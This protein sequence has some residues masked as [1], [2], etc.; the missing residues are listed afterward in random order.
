[1]VVAIPLT[2]NVKADSATY[3][4]LIQPTRK[5]GLSVP[6]VAKIGAIMTLD[7]PKFDYQ[8]GTLDQPD[9]VDIDQQ[10]KLMM[11]LQ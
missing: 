1:M 8:L 3:S 6:S 5:N 2:S 11:K 4:R 9:M 10:L 7:R